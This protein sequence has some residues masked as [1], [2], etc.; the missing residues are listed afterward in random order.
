V[1]TVYDDHVFQFNAIGVRSEGY[2][3]VSCDCWV[4]TKTGSCC[5]SL[6]VFRLDLGARFDFAA[7]VARAKK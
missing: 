1:S 7:T 4:G 6:C 5:T 2:E 3:T